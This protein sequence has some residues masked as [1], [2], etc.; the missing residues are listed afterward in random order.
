[1][2]FF[3]SDSQIVHSSPNLFLPQ[4][5]TLLYSLLCSSVLCSYKGSLQCLLMPAFPPCWT[6]LCSDCAAHHAV[7]PPSWLWDGPSE[8]DLWLPLS[9]NSRP[10]P[11]TVP[12]LSIPFSSCKDVMACLVSDPSPLI[13]V[14]PP[15]P[16]PCLGRLVRSR[17]T[18][19]SN[20][21][22]WKFLHAA[23]LDQWS[24]HLVGLHLA[25]S[26]YAPVR[27]GGRGGGALSFHCSIVFCQDEFGTQ[28]IKR[29]GS[30]FLRCE[31]KSDISYFCLPRVKVF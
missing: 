20:K 4:A 25:S 14:T 17:L 19:T 31:V 7:L 21:I 18:K 15:Q 24:L 16:L 5:V 2:S 1:M 28:I 12:L 8:E 11:C 23:F 29:W 3:C 9:L 6:H 22:V 13:S 30:M 10:V 27:V 26:S